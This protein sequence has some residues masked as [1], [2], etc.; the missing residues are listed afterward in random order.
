[1]QCLISENT[2]LRSVR[3]TMSQFQQIHLSA[4][5]GTSKRSSHSS[6]IAEFS[7]QP[8]ICLHHLFVILSQILTFTAPSLQID[9]IIFVFSKKIFSHPRTFLTSA[10]STSLLAIPLMT[11]T[12]II[13]KHLEQCESTELQNRFSLFQSESEIEN[14]ILGHH[15]SNGNNPTK[16]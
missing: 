12:E 1:M 7:D 13:S 9:Q 2:K 11:T 15:S 16:S 14:I 6:L 8:Q 10:L 4:R 5:I 3:N